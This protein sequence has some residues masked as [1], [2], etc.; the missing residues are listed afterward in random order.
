M[1][2]AQA[3]PT[4]ALRPGENVTD[5]PTVA[6]TPMPD[7]TTATVSP[8]ANETVHTVRTTPL[9]GGALTDDGVPRSPDPLGLVREGMRVFEAAGKEIGK[10]DQVK[11]G[12]PAAATTQGQDIDP[13]PAASLLGAVL[14]GAADDAVPEALRAEALRL[15]FIHI[16]SKGWFSKN[17]LALASQV[18]GV[19]GDR[20]LLN[21]AADELA[22]V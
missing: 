20:V 7:G 17:R 21:V 14:V 1:S 13:A 10:V 22:E 19:D 3:E 5:D 2:G 15:G 11:M 18:A 12:D 4:D 16:D 6:R 8:F 9:G